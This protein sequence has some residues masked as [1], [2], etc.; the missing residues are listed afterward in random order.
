ML[1]AV[2]SAHAAYKNRGKKRNDAI[3][4]SAEFQSKSESMALRDTGFYNSMHS[5]INI[6]GAVGDTEIDI[7]RGNHALF[8]VFDN[9]ER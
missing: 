8:R 4:I 3:F 6:G 5:G 1:Q 7:S 2:C 9:P